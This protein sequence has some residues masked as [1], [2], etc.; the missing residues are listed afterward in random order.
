MRA[1]VLAQ[2]SEE[3]GNCLFCLI[4]SYALAD[5]KYAVSVKCGTQRCHCELVTNVVYDN[6]EDIL[7]PGSY[8]VL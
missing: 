5:H 3:L 8:P 6:F 2:K 4:A 1:S 7:V